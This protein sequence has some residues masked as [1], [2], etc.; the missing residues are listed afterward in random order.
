MSVAI[1]ISPI[2]RQVLPLLL[3]LALAAGFA[4]GLVAFPHPGRLAAVAAA[5]AE[6]AA[7]GKPPAVR[8]AMDL[9]LW[10]VCAGG[11]TLTLAL[12]ASLRWWGQRHG[13]VV[14][15]GAPV[16]RRVILPLLLATG[17]AMTARLPRMTHSFWNDEETTMQDYAWGEWRQDKQ[18]KWKFR[19]VPWEDTLFYNR[20][21]SNH[22]L[23]SISTRLTLGAA[24]KLGIGHPGGG[25]GRFCEASARLV[26]LLASL[27]TIFLLGWLIGRSGYPAAGVA[28]AFL[29]AVHP[30]HVRYSVEIRGYSMMLCA[31]LVCLACLWQALAIG[32]RRWWLGF[33][34]AEA[35]FLLCFAG[36]VYMALAING[37]VMLYLLCGKTGD[38]AVRWQAIRAL[39]GW[40]L[41][42]AL[43]VVFLMAPSLPQFA[44]YL[45]E[46][47]RMIAFTKDF[48]WEMDYLSHLLSGLRLTGDRP[49]ESLGIALRDMGMAGRL[50]LWIGP[51]AALLGLIRLLVMP[52]S[53]FARLLAAVFLLAPIL[54]YAHN[55]WAD[56]PAM[57]WY[58]L[59]SVLALCLG[60]GALLGAVADTRKSRA[61]ALAGAVG[62]AVLLAAW[63]PVALKADRVLAKVPRQPMREV[64]TVMADRAPTYGAGGAKDRL[65]LTF[66][67]S[68]KR[69]RT[70][71]PEV[72]VIDSTTELESAVHAADR[73]GQAMVI[74]YC[75][76]NLA[77]REPD[78]PADG[79]L[80]RALDSGAHGFAKSGVVQGMEELFSY[81]VFRRAPGVEM[82][83]AAKAL[84]DSLDAGQKQ[85]AGY[86]F[87]SPER[88]NWAFVPKERAG[89]PLS[90]LSA[91]Q[92]DLVRKLLASALSEKG[93][94]K[95]DAIMALEALLGEM[96]K[97]PDYRDPAKYHTT[98]FGEPGSGKPWGWRFEGHHLS[99]NMMLDPAR[100]IFATPSF[101]GAN[102]AEVRDGRMKGSRPLAIEEDLARTLATTLNDAGGKVI[103]SNQAPRDILTAAD[104]QVR[105]LDPVGVAA[106]EM[107]GTQRTALV[108][109]IAAYAN[110]HRA[111][112]ATA[113]IERIQSELDGI[114]FGWAGS[115]VPGEAYY[116]R[117]QG[118]SLLIEAANV[119]NNANHIHTVWRDPTRDFGRDELGDHQ[120]EHDLQSD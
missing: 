69:L 71:A 23:N 109:L 117:I 43:P 89:I 55:K 40:N 14:D 68:A 33:A 63:L 88:E 30:W 58:L 81:H 102:P 119:Q 70:Y 20:G 11:L 32:K 10:W 3:L 107:T 94:M 35:S 86:G 75:G 54:S 67:T 42:A 113:H 103:F 1:M 50:V 19:P 13:Q 6:R 99:I 59:F 49:G 108:E 93:L 87:H 24:A 95:V 72:Q 84:V 5:I 65:L 112:I 25:D 85:Q 76:R 38:R 4:C 7:Q 61:G 39:I 29:L 52:R 34:A 115:L 16:R 90:A 110:R 100:G 78:R 27:A 18:E 74:A 2:H 45:K 46:G 62:F 15:P 8:Q 57:P 41:L 105:Q 53:A 114:R 120:R 47:K 92:Q 9:T 31:M 79:D 82:V 101:M 83:S 44:Y 111:W 60:W 97:R 56:N 22:I 26:P 36:S 73:R 64:A 28:A 21:G 77:L 96:E 17:L 80:V 98:I 106:P 51:L 37:L 118:K 48:G 12:A 116:Y 91:A 104:R 66:G